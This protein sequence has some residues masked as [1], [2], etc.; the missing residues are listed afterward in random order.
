MCQLFR[1]AI[2][3]EQLRDSVR[4]AQR[5]VNV[6]V[7]VAAS[8]REVLVPQFA[9]RNDL[10][11]GLSVRPRLNRKLVAARFAEDNQVALTL[12]TD[13]KLVAFFARNLH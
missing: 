12:A 8:R 11:D 3:I 2:E 6:D 10:N 7:T 4:L 5:R 13:Q 9:E 1:I